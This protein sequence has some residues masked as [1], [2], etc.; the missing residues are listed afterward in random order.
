M[1]VYFYRCPTGSDVS[2][3]PLGAEVT[4][5][6][7]VPGDNYYGR[8]RLDVFPGTGLPLPRCCPGVQWKD[9]SY[10]I[11]NIRIPRGQ[12]PSLSD[13]WGTSIISLFVSIFIDDNLW[14][15][16]TWLCG[17]SY[18]CTLVMFQNEDV[19]I[20]TYMTDFKHD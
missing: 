18:G 11:N 16:S 8:L 10:R 1:F 15:L 7:V 12:V 9:N 17:F 3:I 6:C 5:V 2:D 4:S 14:F 20:Y 13:D 19:T